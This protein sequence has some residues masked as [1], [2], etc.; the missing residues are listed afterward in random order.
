MLYVLYR[1]QGS[2]SS[3]KASTVKSREII[4]PFFEAFGVFLLPDG[5][6]KII[7]DH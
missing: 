7:Q 1:K 3:G 6:A 4:D 2:E 5:V